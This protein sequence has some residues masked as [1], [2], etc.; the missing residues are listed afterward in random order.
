[1]GGKGWRNDGNACIAWWGVPP[2]SKSVRSMQGD[3]GKGKESVGGYLF[4]LGMG[5]YYWSVCGLWGG[6][7]GFI[8]KWL[9]N[10]GQVG[11]HE[12]WSGR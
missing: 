6:V 9:D 3:F 12:L 1:M 10:G 5:E 8:V 4:G 11:G 7:W 2:G